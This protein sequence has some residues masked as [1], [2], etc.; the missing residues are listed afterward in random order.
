MKVEIILSIVIAVCTV[1]YTIINSLLWFESRSTRKQK[2]SPHIIAYLKSTEDHVM[3][4]LHIKNIGEGLAKNVKVKILKDYKQFGKN[5][6]FLSELGT[7]KNGFNSFPPQYE[8]KY[9][10]NTNT[11]IYKTEKDEKIELELNYESC[12]NRKFTEI[13]ELPFN[14]L[15]GQNYSS[16]PETYIGK[17]SYYLN[18]MNATLKK[19]E[20][21]MN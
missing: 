3:M 13:F 21:K 19:L 20:K 8:L 1:L 7:M 15:F 4:S 2:T 12:D 11:D 5:N 10:I 17:I 16:P 6:Q 9:Y 18:E 14:Q